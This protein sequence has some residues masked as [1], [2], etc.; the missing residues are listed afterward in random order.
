MKR[1]AETEQISKK[2]AVEETNYQ[3]NWRTTYIVTDERLTPFDVRM[4]VRVEVADVF[5]TDVRLVEGDRLLYQKCRK[6]I[7]RHLFRKHGILGSD[8]RYTIYVSFGSEPN[9]T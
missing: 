5:H 2:P 1:I 6:D 4:T 9:A 7:L 3:N 8:T